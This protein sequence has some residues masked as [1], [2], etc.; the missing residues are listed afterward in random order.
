MSLISLI[1]QKNM[2]GLYTTEVQEFHVQ[3][4]VMKR[5]IKR[6]L[7][8]LWSHLTRKLQIN[9]E[10]FMTQWIMTFFTGWITDERYLL[11]IFD[12]I[13]VSIYGDTEE[14]D[15]AMLSWIFIF[16]VILAILERNQEALLAMNDISDVAEH[17]KKM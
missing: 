1:L 15:Q 13:L 8:D 17:F 4:F 12:N 11:P 2:R 7:P 10:L 9:V 14:E 16:S 3:N 5:L 6:C